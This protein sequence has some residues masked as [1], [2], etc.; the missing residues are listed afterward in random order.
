MTRIG[1]ILLVSIF[2]VQTFAQ[3]KSYYPE[4]KSSKKETEKQNKEKNKQIFDTHLFAAL[5]AK[6]LEDYDEAIKNFEKCIKFDSKNPVPYYELSKINATNGN[7]NI[8][9]EQIEKAV[10]E[11]CK[12]SSGSPYL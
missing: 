11:Q 12:L 4:L 9:T 10:Q 6:S 5:K 8:A 2:S 1:L 3:W 7:Y